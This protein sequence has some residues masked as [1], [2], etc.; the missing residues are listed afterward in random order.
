MPILT[1]RA[2]KEDEVISISKK[3]IDE[4]EDLLECPRE[5][6]TIE[7]RNSTF[8]KDGEIC[9]GYPIIDVSWFDRGQEVQDKAAEIITRYIKGLGHE[10][11]DVIFHVL[12]E[13]LYYENGVHF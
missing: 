6:F 11:V 2:I 12:Q 10:T 9:N 1:L 7:L 3:L 13:K 5:Y 4:L 8:V